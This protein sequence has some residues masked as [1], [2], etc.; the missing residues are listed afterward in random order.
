MTGGDVEPDG[1][2]DLDGTAPVGQLG[3]MEEEL[4]TVRAANRAEAPVHVEGDDRSLNAHVDHWKPVPQW[5][6]FES[7]SSMMSVAP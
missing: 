1:N 4:S 3:A 7:A 6:I 2:A 5:T